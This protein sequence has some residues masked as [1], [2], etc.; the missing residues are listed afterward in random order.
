MIKE[1]VLISLIL[2]LLSIAVF[3]IAS[4]NANVGVVTSSASPNYAVGVTIKSLGAVGFELTVEGNLG[5][6]FDLRKVGSIQQ[7]NFMPSILLSLPS[8]EIRP[9]AGIGI[10][11]SYDV[12]DGKFSPIS[13]EPLYYRGGVDVFFKG[14]SLF[15]EAQGTF[16]YQPKWSF[17][18]IN[19]WRFGAGLAF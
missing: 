3:G 5:S 2:S 8:G 19:E 17:S 12:P 16:N 13:L 9:Y 18:G 1:L 6:S 7:W 14:F 4:I 10:L 15:A 11:T